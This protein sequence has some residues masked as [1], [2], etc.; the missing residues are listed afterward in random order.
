VLY[1]QRKQ[2]HRLEKMRFS[3]ATC[4][5]P[6]K[7]NKN[8][9]RLTFIQ[10]LI[11]RP[12]VMLS[13]LNV[14]W[15]VSYIQKSACQENWKHFLASLICQDQTNNNPR[16]H[17]WWSSDKHQSS[18]LLHAQVVISHSQCRSSRGCICSHQVQRTVIKDM[19]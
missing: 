19:R 8:M 5:I 3:P 18:Y 15:D 4:L 13:L 10:L 9:I 1:F 6:N 2:P 7:T 11:P 14:H 17:R 12:E 16:F